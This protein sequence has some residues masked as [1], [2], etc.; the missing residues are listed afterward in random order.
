M[1]RRTFIAALGGLAAGL[2]LVRRRGEAKDPPACNPGDI[3]SIAVDGKCSGSIVLWTVTHYDERGRIV[4]HKTHEGKAL[5]PVPPS[6]VHFS[7]R[8]RLEAWS[9]QW[10]VKV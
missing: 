4:L 1:N 7:D 3:R 9:N 6:D 8:L 10:V 2:G 5:T